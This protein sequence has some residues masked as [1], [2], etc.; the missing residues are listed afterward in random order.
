MA[1]E[2]KISIE[3]SLTDA[4]AAFKTI[5][6]EARETVSDIIRT[7]TTQAKTEAQLARDKVRNERQA[8]NEIR[9][10]HAETARN[11][12]QQER[13]ADQASRA[14]LRFRNAQ[15]RRNADNFLNNFDNTQTQGAG[16]FGI[17]N[18]LI[19]LATFAAAKQ[20]LDS[21]TE[22]A[23]AAS[24]SQRSLAS[25]AKQT[26]IAYQE[27]NKQ[28]LEFGRLT[29]Q[30]DVAARQSFGKI[31]NIADIAG[32]KQDL[33]LIQRRFADITA[34][35]GL[36][37][38][39]VNTLAQQLVSG[40]DEALNRLGIADP[41][42]LYERYAKSLNRTVASLNE[43]EKAQARL[44]AVLDKAA[45]FDG[46]AERRLT[47]TATAAERLSRNLENLKNALAEKFV[48]PVGSFAN[49]LT[50]ILTGSASPEQLSEARFAQANAD[51]LR[52]TQEVVKLLADEQKKFE[53][54]QRNPNASFQNFAL[55]RARFSL[56]DFFAPNEGEDT[57]AFLRRREE[58][59]KKGLEEATKIR[60]D[61]KKALEATAKDPRATIPFLR[62]ALKD[63]SE[64][65]GILDPKDRTEL[66]QKLVDTIQKIIADAREKLRK[67]RTDVLDLSSGLNQQ[68]FSDNPYVRLFSDAQKAAERLRE[69]T[70]FLSADV[71]NVLITQQAQALGGQLFGARLDT[72]LQALDLR[73]QARLLRNTVNAD[74]VDS[75]IRGLVSNPNFN[76][77]QLQI[78]SADLKRQADP[79]AN[80]LDRLNE[81]LRFVENLRDKNQD[82]IQAASLADKRI[83]SLTTGL[84]QE[85]LTPEIREKA[86]QARE[87]EATRLE[88]LEQE[89]LNA[90]NEQTRLLTSLNTS[91]DKVL[92]KVVQGV[93]IEGQGS[94]IQI[95]VSD[96]GVQ[97][98]LGSAPN[99]DDTANAF[100]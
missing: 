15:A 44:N 45:L 78:F 81:Q 97:T 6:K 10:I 58:I 83:I 18:A 43:T 67:V 23:K 100:N 88:Q 53:E 73:Q 56:N 12:A 46:E 11:R 19:P 35:R 55:S 20:G 31:V 28:A 5:A 64:S 39:D 36:S 14:S 98:R 86:A 54:A 37:A 25:F 40:Q 41:S 48:Q 87:R 65:G 95:E 99:A 96:T 82:L 69:T 63:L 4:R 9:R 38:E 70:K 60:D 17:G 27:L 57:Q 71:R 75:L 76:N 80:A 29:N 51:S 85:Q 90:R 72:G 92:Q 22:R 1:N 49:F 62:L 59:V 2:I 52:R 7:E 66:S 33:A 34:A 24:D 3:A 42:V 68:I 32:R 50:T 30:S 77:K 93:P 89:A 79:N 84:S 26:G 61:F 47:D 94:L 16:G 91:L 8:A 74:N 13:I 21:I